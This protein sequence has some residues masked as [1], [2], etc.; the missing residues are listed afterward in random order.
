LGEVDAIL[1]A[2]GQ[3]TTEDQQCRA[4]A[5]VL[6]AMNAYDHY[7]EVE[8]NNYVLS[9]YVVGAPDNELASIIEQLGHWQLDEDEAHI[10]QL[11]PVISV[12][13]IF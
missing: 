1:S 2:E 9:N 13:F 5:H 10:Q 11:N 4:M 12:R 7:D 3:Q 8:M 6:R